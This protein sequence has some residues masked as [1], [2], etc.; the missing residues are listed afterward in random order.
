VRV[1]ENRR[2]VC[3]SLTE[4][5]VV[6]LVLWDLSGAEILGGHHAAG[7]QDA[8]KLIEERIL[9]ADCAIKRDSQSLRGAE[10][11][12]REVNRERQR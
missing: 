11:V 9:R 12:G 3:V 2:K 5:I 10:R 8:E 1:E 4:T 7:R 6:P